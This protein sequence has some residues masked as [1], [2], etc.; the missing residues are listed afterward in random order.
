MITYV[1]PIQRMKNLLTPF[2]TYVLGVLARIIISAVTWAESA[3]HK[4]YV[5]KAYWVTRKQY[6]AMSGTQR[7]KVAALVTP[8]R[9]GKLSSFGGDVPVGTFRHTFSR[10]FGVGPLESVLITSAIKGE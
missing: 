6:Q 3:A 2:T 9:L 10:D 8:D 1:K 7:A 4:A 5:Q